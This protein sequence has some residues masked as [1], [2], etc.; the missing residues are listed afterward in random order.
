MPSFGANGWPEQLFNTLQNGVG[1]LVNG[2]GG[3]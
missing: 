1:R 3:Q 2:Q